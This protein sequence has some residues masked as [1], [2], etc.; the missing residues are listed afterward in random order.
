MPTQSPPAPGTNVVRLSAAAKRTFSPALVSTIAATVGA[1]AINDT[2]LLQ[3]YLEEAAALDLNPLL[4]EI[5]LAQMPGKNG[6]PGRLAVM[7]GRD[8]YLKI[9]RRDEHFID[10][11]ADVV[12][13]NDVFRVR[14]AENGKRTIVHEYDHPS[15]R[16]EVVGAYAIL[17]RQ[18]KPDRYFYA[19]RAEYAKDAARSAWSFLHAMMVKAATSY[20][21]RITYGV[22]GPVPFD[23]LGAGLDLPGASG[24]LGAADVGD[25]QPLDPEIAPL[26]ERIRDLDPTAFTEGV[27]RARTQ[28]ATPVQL[29]QVKRELEQWLAENE[30]EDAVVVADDV[31]PS[32]EAAMAENGVEGAQE[33]VSGDV[34]P[35]AGEETGADWT[36]AQA[37]WESDATWRAQVHPFLER[38]TAIDELRENA[39]EKQD[40]ELVDELNWLDQQLTT[41]GVP[42]G[43]RP[44]SSGDDSV[45]F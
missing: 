27:L 39:N 5:W 6:A 26:Y 32:A 19:P 1:P 37:R 4:N 7:V 40:A 29:A 3:R 33:A 24:G 42:L 22:S 38:L 34:E 11:D 17:R 16:G 44:R 25:F 21:T 18:G 43:W 13:E 41:L 9:A 20:I 28:G 8:G 31:S 15:K 2:A 45:D 36:A 35:E 14:R 23:E 12:C 10:V 30:P